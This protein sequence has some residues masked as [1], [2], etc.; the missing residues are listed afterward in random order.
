MAF[1]AGGLTD[2]YARLYAEQLAAEFGIQAIV[3]NKPGAGAIIAIDAMAKS[4]A[5]GYTL[6]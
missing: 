5:D 3:A 6:P 2:F 4:P 1:A